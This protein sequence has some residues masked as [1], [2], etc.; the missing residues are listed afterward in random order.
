MRSEVATPGSH[1]LEFAK[2]AMNAKVSSIGRVVWMRSCSFV[3][4]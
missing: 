4:S 2:S 1:R 3:I